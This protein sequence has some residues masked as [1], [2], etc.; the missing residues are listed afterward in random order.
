[1]HYADPSS[2]HRPDFKGDLCFANRQEAALGSPM[3]G[4]SSLLT[5]LMGAGES[6]LSATLAGGLNQLQS[7]MNHSQAEL[8]RASAELEELLKK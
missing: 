4:S 6:A 7:K 1:V 5:S 8:D 3:Q 2:W